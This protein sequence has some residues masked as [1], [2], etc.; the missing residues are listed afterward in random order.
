MLWIDLPHSH[1]AR[2]G[3]A[4]HINDQRVY[5]PNDEAKQNKTEQ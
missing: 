5:P 1:K 2:T 3:L 4:I